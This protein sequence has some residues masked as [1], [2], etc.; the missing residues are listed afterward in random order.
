[1]ISIASWIGIG[2]AMAM[3]PKDAWL[4]AIGKEVR[5]FDASVGD[6]KL[7]ASSDGSQLLIVGRKR[8]SV[9]EKTASVWSPE[10]KLISRLKLDPNYGFRPISFTADGTQIFA[11]GGWITHARW[12]AKSGELI[13]FQ[14]TIG[15]Q[16]G[17]LLISTAWR[18]LE[19]RRHAGE[20]QSSHERRKGEFGTYFVFFAAFLHPWD[21]TTLAVTRDG[22]RQVLGTAVSDFISNSSPL[23]FIQVWDAEQGRVVK[24]FFPAEW[25]Q[26]LFE[27]CQ[28][29]DRAKGSVRLIL[30]WIESRFLS[31]Q[32]S[33][34]VANA[35][36][37]ISHPVPIG[38]PVS[39]GSPWFDR[40]FRIQKNCFALFS[41]VD[42]LAINS[43]YSSDALL[44]PFAIS[45]DG[46]Y[47]ASCFGGP[48]IQVWDLTTGS[49]VQW[50][51]TGW[52]DEISFGPDNKT[53]IVA[54]NDDQ[55]RAILSRW[56][57]ESGRC[58]WNVPAYYEEKQ[59][60]KYS[61]D[62]K[63]AVVCGWIWGVSIWDVKTGK[64]LGRIGAAG[65]NAPSDGV[66]LGDS[67]NV[68]TIT[69][70]GDEK[71]IVQIW[72]LPK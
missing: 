40:F 69:D 39:S 31:L 70:A 29:L 3:V 14:R 7:A 65:R 18:W 53:L 13:R 30:D 11:T 33:V 42:Q 23:L 67:R 5:R 17:Q 64:P 49:L 4:P 19:P 50:L 37:S 12:D 41:L 34:P 10:G 62:G 51:P 28:K 46:R 16:L 1:M 35:P 45:N 55:R 6:E 26:Q 32:P 71:A 9:D 8:A 54:G 44:A 63:R 66:F 22:R 68:V 43:H 2:L 61:P 57:V 21:T 52:A 24:K 27:Y 56:D 48:S 47:L 20:T 38:N 15:E 60:I 58:L 59:R 36:G 25:P 72:Q